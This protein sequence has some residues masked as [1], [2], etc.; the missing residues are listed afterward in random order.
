VITGFDA[1]TAT[2]N[3]DAALNHAAAFAQGS[4]SVV[5]PYTIFSAPL[6]RFATVGEVDAPLKPQVVLSRGV[7]SS[8]AADAEFETAQ[9][10]TMALV[11]LLDAATLML[12]TALFLTPLEKMGKKVQLQLEISKLS[13]LS[14]LCIILHCSAALDS[15]CSTEYCSCS[16]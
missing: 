6:D 10:L 7:Q 13:F 8:V 2:D 15:A 12:A 9:W 5:K 16:C 3:R 4:I 1:S 11:L 14:S